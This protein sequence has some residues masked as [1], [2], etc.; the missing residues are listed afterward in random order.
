MADHMIWLQTGLCLIYII[1]VDNFPQA[2]EK[3]ASFE[4]QAATKQKE[5]EQFEGTNWVPLYQHAAL[6]RKNCISNSHLVFFSNKREY[7]LLVHCVT[8]FL[9]KYK[10]FRMSRQVLLIL[11]SEIRVL[12]IQTFE[13]LTQSV[14][15]RCILC[16]I[17][18]PVC[19]GWEESGRCWG[20]M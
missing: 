20:L 14:A 13:K 6:L 3:A 15:C 9:L 4:E 2:Q 12:V 10:T 11:E 19:V 5:N 7:M 8:M 18:S 16:V 17:I 1:T